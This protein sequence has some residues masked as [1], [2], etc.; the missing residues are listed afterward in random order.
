MFLIPVPIDKKALRDER[1]K[2]PK[3]WSEEPSVSIFMIQI[4][5]HDPEEIL[6]KGPFSL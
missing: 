2:L 6:T 4:T 3:D 5:Y 1:G